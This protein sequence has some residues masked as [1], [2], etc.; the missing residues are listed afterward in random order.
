MRFFQ[1]FLFQCYPNYPI[2]AEN[3]WTHE[4]PSLSERVSTPIPS[5]RSL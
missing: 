2:G 1:H 4:I 5:A 3:I